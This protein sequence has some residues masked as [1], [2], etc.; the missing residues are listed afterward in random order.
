MTGLEN[1]F[2][3]ILVGFMAY[4]YIGTMGMALFSYL[5]RPLTPAQWLGGRHR[6]VR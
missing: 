6:R 2:L 3:Y 1:I 5:V 4:L